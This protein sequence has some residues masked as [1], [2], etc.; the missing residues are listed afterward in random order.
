MLPANSIKDDIMALDFSKLSPEELIAAESA[1]LT[2]QAL[3]QVVKTAPHGHGME[4][5]EVAIQNQ[6]KAHL[7]KMLS[8]AVE[9]HAEAQKK[10]ACAAADAVV[11]RLPGSNAAR[12][13]HF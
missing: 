13:K 5:L 6:G 8:A 12:K 9:S 4:N 2:M 10:T 7:R 11:E 3:V 1:V